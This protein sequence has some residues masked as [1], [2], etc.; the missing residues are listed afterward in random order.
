MGAGAAARRAFAF[1]LSESTARR[2]RTGVPAGTLLTGGPAEGGPPGNPAEHLRRAPARIDCQKGSLYGGGSPR[3]ALESQA[4]A[5]AP[6]H[7]RKADGA[8][9]LLRPGGGAGD[10]DETVAGRCQARW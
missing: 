8:G 3:R 10:N 2:R 7:G 9:F 4:G 5:V 1:R 6:P